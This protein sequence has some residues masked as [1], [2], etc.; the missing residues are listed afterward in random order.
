MKKIILLLSIV[1]TTNLNAQSFSDYEQYQIDKSHNSILQHINT[2]IYE[3]NHDDNLFIKTS[4]SSQL[5][6]NQLFGEEIIVSTIDSIYFVLHSNY[7]RIYIPECNIL[8]SIHCIGTTQYNLGNHL[9]LFI[10]L[11]RQARLEYALK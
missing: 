1:V 10:T 3:I 4:S 6:M 5:T 8:Y 2:S 9:L 7:Y 11:I